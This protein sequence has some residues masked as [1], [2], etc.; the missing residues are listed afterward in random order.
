MRLRVT[1]STRAAL[2]ADRAE[3]ATRFIERLTGLL[4][5]AQL[6]A[7]EGLQIVPCNC[8][9]TFFMRFP[10][11]VIFLDG[12]Q[13]VLKIAPRTPPWRVIGCSQARSVLELPAGTVEKTGTRPADELDFE[14]C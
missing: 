4:G 13:R 9:H 11:D 1:N 7:G 8:I 14:L 6:D 3:R 2:L 12:A 10:I 5:R